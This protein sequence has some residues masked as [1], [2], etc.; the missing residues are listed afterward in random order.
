MCVAYIIISMYFE[1]RSEYELKMS[2]EIKL[3]PPPPPSIVMNPDK[4]NSGTQRGV[5]DEEDNIE[6][7]D[8][9]NNACTSCS[10]SSK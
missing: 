3:A 1:I 6:S 9:T 8:G 4:K 7:L 5:N 10:N 2:D